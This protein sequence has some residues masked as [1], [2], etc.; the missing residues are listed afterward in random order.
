MLSALANNKMK[1]CFLPS[2]ALLVLQV[3]SLDQVTFRG[4]RSSP[5]GAT[6]AGQQEFP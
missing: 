4:Q 5:L 2:S 6:Q 1:I 3:R